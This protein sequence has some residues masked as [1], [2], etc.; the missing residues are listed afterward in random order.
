MILGRQIRCLKRWVFSFVFGGVVRAGEV[1]PYLEEQKY[2]GDLRM[3]RGD[4]IVP[5]SIQWFLHSSRSIE[6]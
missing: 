3:I 2:D 5:Y 6:L 1:A 4:E